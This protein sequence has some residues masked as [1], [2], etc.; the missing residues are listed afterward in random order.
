LTGRR[1]SK[2]NAIN[3]ERGK[4]KKYERKELGGKLNQRTPVTPKGRAKEK[5]VPVHHGFKRAEAPK[6]EETK[7]WGR[8]MNCN[9][10]M[11][12]VNTNWQSE[13][14]GSRETRVGAKTKAEKKKKEC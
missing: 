5:S 1:L 11:L 9:I 2:F 13:E 8:S 12:E 7:Q 14:R 3:R 10:G 6:G 4:K